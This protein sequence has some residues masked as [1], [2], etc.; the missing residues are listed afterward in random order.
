MWLCPLPQN[1]LALPLLVCRKLDGLL[2]SR[3]WHPQLGGLREVYL[4]PGLQRRPV[5]QRVAGRRAAL[6]EV[7]RCCPAGGSLALRFASPLP[8]PARRSCSPPPGCRH[9]SPGLPCSSSGLTLPCVHQVCLFR[10]VW[11]VVSKERELLHWMSI[12][13]VNGC[14]VW[15]F[16]FFINCNGK[17]WSYFCKLDKKFENWGTFL[18]ILIY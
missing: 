16:V 3:L 12:H 9:L 2:G 11:G 1:S 4:V 13:S 8:A 7:W 15:V 18:G 14:S 17:L 5:L 6:A 10:N